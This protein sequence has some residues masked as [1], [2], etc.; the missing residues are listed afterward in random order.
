MLLVA[1]LHSLLQ[2]MLNELPTQK[3]NVTHHRV[4]SCASRLSVIALGC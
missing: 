3:L 1:Q 4:R 2:S